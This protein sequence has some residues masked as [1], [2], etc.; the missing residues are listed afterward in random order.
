MKKAGVMTPAFFLLRWDQFAR[1]LPAASIAGGVVAGVAQVLDVHFMRAEAVGGDGTLRGGSV[2]VEMVGVV[3][4]VVHG[5]ASHG[6]TS[7]D[8]R[9]RR[10]QDKKPHDISSVSCF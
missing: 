9:G 2:G 4:M 7:E 3:M 6:S 1:M 8:E 5:L 10:G